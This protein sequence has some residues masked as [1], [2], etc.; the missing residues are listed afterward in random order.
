MALFAAAAAIALWVDRPP[1]GTGRSPSSSPLS[2]RCS[3]AAPALAVPGLAGHAAQTAPARALAPAR[4]AAPRAA[5]R[6]GWAGW[7]A[8]SILWVRT[9]AGDA[10]S[11][12]LGR[13]VP[14]F[15]N[16]AFVSVL[17]PDRE[18]GR[19][20]AS[21]TSRSCRRCGRRPTASRSS[22]RWACSPL[23]WWLGG[24]NLLRTKPRLGAARE[25]RGAAADGR[26]PACCGAPCSGETALVVGGRARRSVLS[27]LAAAR[28]GAR[29]SSVQTLA[30]V[31]PGARR[32]S[33]PP[34]RLYA[35]GAR[36]PQ[37]A[38]RAELLR[39]PD[40][41]GR[42]ARHGRRCH[43]QFE[44]LDMQMGNQQ[45]SAH[46]DAPGHIHPHAPALGHGRAA[47]ACS[48]PCTPKQANRRSRPSSSTTPAG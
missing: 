3:P 23:R 20:H 42:T 7:S 44:M 45:S 1:R 38:R 39:A 9:A 47:G 2:G 17:R 4:L 27:S 43:A 12:S 24:V 46:R 6:C 25:R 41:Q 22:S 28:R 36:Q 48:S 40:D 31:G 21:S 8:C 33:R 34:G 26:R 35:Q 18:R 30:T 16:V 29:R 37:H 10:R 5:G 13:V 11:R 19:R 32:V 14:R 15:S